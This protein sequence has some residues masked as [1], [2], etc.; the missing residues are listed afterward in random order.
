MKSLSIAQIRAITQ[1]NIRNNVWRR[2]HLLGTEYHAPLTDGVGARSVL[3]VQ[4][5]VSAIYV[6]F[7]ALSAM[8]TKPEEP[9][10]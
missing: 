1:E 9:Q 3:V 4:P 7:T 5:L 8:E 10:W 2:G 6:P